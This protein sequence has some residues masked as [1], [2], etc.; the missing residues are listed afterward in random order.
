VAT[1]KKKIVDIEAELDES[2]EED[3]L[4]EIGEEIVRLGK[5]IIQETSSFK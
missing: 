5:E 4:K 3:E 2:W 1:L